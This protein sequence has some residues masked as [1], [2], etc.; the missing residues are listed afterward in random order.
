VLPAWIFMLGLVL[1]GHCTKAVNKP[2][3]FVSDPP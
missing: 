3:F 1:S 2:G